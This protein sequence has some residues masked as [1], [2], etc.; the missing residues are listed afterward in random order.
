[1]KQDYLWDKTGADPEIES[2]E[3]ALA[4][5]RYKE[6]AP[7]ALPAKIIPFKKESPRRSFRFAYAIA[8][9]TAFLMIG[10]G[11]WFQISTNETATQESIAQTIQPQI[12][13]PPPNVEAVE[14]PAPIVKNAKTSPNITIE[15]AGRIS[16]PKVVRK[17][18]AIPAVVRPTEKKDKNIEAKK[19]DVQLTKE[20]QY[21][22]DQLMLAL[23]IT[24][25]KLKLVKDKVEGFEE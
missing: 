21:A 4:V 9:C 14:N 13:E 7:P 15:S 17:N 16:A 1:M 6:I 20:E 24:S 3:N 10:L 25:S 23:S 11:V 19:S 8:A 5:F 12:P 18:K 2:L 22:Y